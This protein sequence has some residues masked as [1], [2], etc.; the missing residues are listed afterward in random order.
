[1]T[2][3][4]Y[5]KGVTPD[6]SAFLQF[7]FWQPILYLD[8]ES[9]WPES[10]E[11]SARWVGMARSIGDA[12]T[13]WVLDDQ[14]KQLLARSVVRPFNQNLRV[15]WDPSLVDNQE[16]TTATHGGDVI[17]KESPED[18]DNH[19]LEDDQQ[20]VEISQ[21]SYMPRSNQPALKPSYENPG[22]DTTR[23]TFPKDNERITRSKGKLILD[24]VPIPLDPTIQTFVREGKKPYKSLNYKLD[25]TPKEDHGNLP[26]SESVPELI[27]RTIQRKPSPRRSKRIRRKRTTWAPSRDTKALTVSSS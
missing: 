2:P 26:I 8:H 24:N 7:T 27:P 18:L 16:K 5:Q 3:L 10:K 22:L 21:S 14:S 4:Q 19:E 25:Y 13:F 1:M 6:I 15:K 23:L 9:H 20:E 12:L 11:R 17:P